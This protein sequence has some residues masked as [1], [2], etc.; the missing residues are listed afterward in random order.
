MAKSDHTRITS[1]VPMQNDI[2]NV[3][4][5]RY[6][7]SKQIPSMDYIHTA[8]GNIELDFEMAKAVQEAL[9]RVLYKR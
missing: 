6:A 7:L 1:G 2:H 4:E 8:Y 5:I 9:E 3:D